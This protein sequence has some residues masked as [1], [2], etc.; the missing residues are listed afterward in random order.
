[1]NN[2]KTTINSTSNESLL[3]SLFASL[4]LAINDGTKDGLKKSRCTG[5]LWGYP[6][7]K[8][9]KA[10]RKVLYRKSDLDAF[11][12]QLPKFQNNAEVMEA[13]K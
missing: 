13:N 12:E 10:K 5:E 11:L 9:I 6:A 2:K 1:M 3:S 8:F 7:P 4:Y